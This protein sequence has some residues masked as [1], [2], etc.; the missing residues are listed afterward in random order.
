MDTNNLNEETII[1][2]TTPK[3][4]FVKEYKGHSAYHCTRNNTTSSEPKDER[5]LVSPLKL[6]VK[7]KC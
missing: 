4:I 7:F 3:V 2:I 1:V 5:I 6:E